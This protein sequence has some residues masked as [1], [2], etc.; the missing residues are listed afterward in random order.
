[1]KTF[2]MLLSSHR[3]HAHRASSEEHSEVQVI[4]PSILMLQHFY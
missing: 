1:M 4:A 2:R 3:Y